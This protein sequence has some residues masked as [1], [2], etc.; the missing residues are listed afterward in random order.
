MNHMIET[1]SAGI[2][3]ATGITTKVLLPAAVPIV[4]MGENFISESTG[5]PLTIVVAVGG[6]CW[7]LN[8]RFTRIAHVICAASA[9]LLKLQGLVRVAGLRRMQNWII[10]A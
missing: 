1:I 8:G 7:Y 5:V 10:R 4:A 6:A 3:A 2:A 9:T